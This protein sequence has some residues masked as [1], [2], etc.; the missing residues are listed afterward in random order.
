LN[1]KVISNSLALIFVIFISFSCPVFAD[2]LGTQITGYYGAQ[3]SYPDNNLFDPATNV[4]PADYRNSGGTTVTVSGTAI[5]FGEGDRFLRIT[6]DFTGDTLTL[7]AAPMDLPV[8]STVPV[9]YAFTGVGQFT[10]LATISDNFTDGGLI[11]SLNDQTMTFR[12]A[13]QTEFT[14]PLTAT[15]AIGSISG[16]GEA[17]E[18]STAWL[19]ASVIVGAFFFR[20]RYRLQ[21][22]WRM[23]SW[24]AASRLISGLVLEV[25]K[26]PRR[27]ITSQGS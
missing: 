21:P 14:Q 13:G 12:W 10:S 27:P 3:A 7:T 18:P 6:A 17:P 22:R 25:S 16:A 9:I 11:A 26:S 19:I 24:R 8:T 23:H 20:N 2:L 4:I 5:E 1:R 15:Y